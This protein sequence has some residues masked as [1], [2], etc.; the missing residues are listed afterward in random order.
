VGNFSDKI[1][2]AF[3]PLS[4][5]LKKNITCD[6][7]ADHENAFRATHSIL[8]IVPDLA[9][10]DQN[11]PTSL[12]VDDSLLNGIGFILKKQSEFSTW[13][14]VQ[15]GSRF[16]RPPETRYAMIELECLAASW[17]HPGA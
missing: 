12:A 9:F 5:L 2:E 4:P 8:A 14:V 1:A 7:S 3:A 11:H 6:W 15:A 13:H 10:Y 17:R 16:L